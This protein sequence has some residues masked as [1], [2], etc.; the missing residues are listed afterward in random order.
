MDSE[1][2]LPHEGEP[3]SEDPERMLVP[4]PPPSDSAWPDLPPDAPYRG[5]HWIFIGPNG[6]RGGW[7]VLL[8]VPLFVLFSSIA[9]RLARSSHLLGPRGGPFTPARVIMAELITLAGILGAAAV[10]AL[11]ERRR[12]MDFNL[13][14]PRRA[15]NCFFG[16]I[17]GFAA[18]SLL[19]G[20][21]AMC[22]WLHFG[23]VALSG[24]EVFRY[25]LVWGV[26]FVLVGCAEEGMMRCYLQFTLTRSINF[27]WALGLVAAM[28]RSL[29]LRVKGNGVWGV[30]AAAL[31]GLL[32]CLLLHLNKKPGGPFWYATWVTSILFSFLHTSNG[33]ENWVGIFSTAGIGFVFCMSIRVTGSAWWAIGFHAGWDWAQTYFY[34]T[35]DSGVVAP[36]HLLNTTAMG[37]PFWSGG[38]DGPEGS[39]LIIGVLILLLAWLITI[40]GRRAAALTDLAT[41]G[42]FSA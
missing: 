16:T 7:S 21:M 4:T 30:Y 3:S 26:A 1:T 15:S 42:E 39:I 24:I 28:C 2:P 13:N 32:P 6:L 29:F 25:A 33:G 5:Y 9:G 8:F 36:G 20:T 14:G 22:A 19:V 35:A 37:N 11:I 23:C 18:L 31:L 17:T 27:W 34:G 40:Y 38:T 10:V 41:S 12:L